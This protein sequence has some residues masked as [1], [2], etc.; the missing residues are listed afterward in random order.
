MISRHPRNPG[1]TIPISSTS[2]AS[3]SGHTGLRTA[4]H[5]GVQHERIVAALLERGAD[6]NI[7]DEGDNAFPL[8]FVAETNDALH[9]PA[10]C[11]ARRRSDWRRRPPRARSHRLGHGLRQGRRGGR[12]LPARPRRCAQHLLGDSDRCHRRSAQA[13]PSNRPATLN[14]KMDRTNLRRTPLHLAV[15]KKQPAAL[16]ILIDHGAAA[17]RD[18][19]R[20]LDSARSGGARRRARDGADTD[21][22]RRDDWVARRRCARPSRRYRARAQRRPRRLEARASVGTAHRSRRRHLVWQDDRDVAAIWRCDQCAGRSGNVGG[23]SAR[24]YGAPLPPDGMATPMLPRFSSAT[25]PTSPSATAST[26][27]RL[28]DGRTTPGMRPFA[29]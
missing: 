25:V 18:G 28:R 9:H 19:C 17:R 8:H 4:L 12:Q 5:F 14:R 6:P 15:V 11:G 20:R 3:L 10:P 2:A 16:P 26:A 29:I 21:R 24:L 22:S 7:R 23:R 13:V 27:Q 1:S